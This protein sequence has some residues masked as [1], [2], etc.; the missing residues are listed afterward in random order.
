MEST[1]S[2]FTARR[3]RHT[4]LLTLV[5]ALMITSPA[6]AQQPSARG[7]EITSVDLGP[8]TP[9][10][11]VFLHG[12]LMSTDLWSVQLDEL[13]SDRRCYAVAQ[14]GHGVPRFGD[15]VTMTHWAEVLRT[16]LHGAGI[17][18]AVLVGHSMGGM[19][20][21]E[22]VRRY[23]D[24]VLGLGLVGT[25]DTP[26][27]PAVVAAIEQQLAGWNEQIAAGWA[28]LLIGAE[29]LR[30]NPEWIGGFH[31]SVAGYDREWLPRLMGA[32]QGREDLTGFTPTIDV[33]TVVIHSRTDGAVPFVAGEALAGRIPGAELVAIDGGGHAAPMETPEPVVEGIRRLMAKVESRQ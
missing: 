5:L 20:A 3:C 4:V 19:L 25:T 32:I 2:S 23:P 7:E 27:Q 24:E 13:C 22:Y 30:E 18:R 6:F 26:G 28:A 1:T 8:K 11:L 16:E 31:D 10:A 33:P 15:P 17:E 29:F 12:W 21:I 9:E 14:P